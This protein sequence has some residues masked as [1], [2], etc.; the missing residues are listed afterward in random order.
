M[1]PQAQPQSPQTS[2]TQ[3]VDGTVDKTRP[4]AVRKLPPK[5]TVQSVETADPEL[6]AAL[7]RVSVMPT[8]DNHRAV[9]DEYMR[10]H[11]FDTADEYL[12]TALEID[13]HN[14]MAWDGKARVW[15][16]MGFPQAALPHASRAVH[17]APASAETRNTLGTIL[18]ALGHHAAARAEYEKALSL[19]T[20]L[21]T[22][23]RNMVAGV[24]VA[25]VATPSCDLAY[26]TG[27]TVAGRSK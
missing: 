25:P 15:R 17:F 8:A 4:L 1:A 12:T 11:I 5:A 9:A 3:P 19:D 24:E 6:A 16:D 13:P 23:C 20:T 10:L 18:Q 2:T 26:A 7:L 21:N 14:A 27:A 22:L